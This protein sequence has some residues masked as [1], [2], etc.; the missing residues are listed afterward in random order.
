[1]YT[2]HR[3]RSVE[4]VGRRAHVELVERVGLR[5]HI[6]LKGAAA[7]GGKTVSRARLTTAA[8]TITAVTA[9]RPAKSGSFRPTDGGA[10]VFRVPI[11]VGAGENRTDEPR[12]RVVS[13]SRG[14]IV[15]R[16]IPRRVFA[17]TN[18]KSE[19]FFE[20]RFF[21]SNGSE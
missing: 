9:R 17:E 16:T 1:M 10:A 5:R 14:L 11:R 19:R 7:D 20:R 2:Y 21:D 8:T 12:L 15:N 13:S 3:S 4:D 18:R 6:I